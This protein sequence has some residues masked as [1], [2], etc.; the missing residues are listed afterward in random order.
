LIAS[1]VLVSP[2]RLQL[3]TNAL[4]PPHQH[5]QVFHLLL[6]PE[7]LWETAFQAICRLAINQKQ[8]SYQHYHSINAETSDLSLL[9][10]LAMFY[11]LMKQESPHNAGAKVLTAF[12]QKFLLPRIQVIILLLT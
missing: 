10:D 9:L 8:K 12:S 4:G 5:N 2:T 1:D 7:S 11:C 3:L 6:H